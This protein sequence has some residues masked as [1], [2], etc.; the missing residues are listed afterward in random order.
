M[1]YYSTRLI[2]VQIFLSYLL[3]AIL[4]IGVW[5][6]G[7][8]TF[9][10]IG[11]VFFLALGPMLVYFHQHPPA[12]LGRANAVTVFSPETQRHMAATFKDWSIWDI[13]WMKI[14]RILRLFHTQ[15]DTSGQYGYQGAG[16]L[17]EISG[18]LL[19]LGLGVCLSN[20]KWPRFLL[21][22]LWGTMII[23]TGGLLT[24]N[25]PF[26]PRMASLPLFVAM[27][28]ALGLDFTLRPFDR[29]W[30]RFAPLIWMPIVL[31]VIVFAGWRNYEH[32][33]IRYIGVQ[34]PMTPL[35]QLAHRF[36][37]LPSDV[38]VRL[39]GYPNLGVGH[40]TFRFLAPQL[41]GKDIRNG[42]EYIENY[43]PGEQQELWVFVFGPNMK[44]YPGAVREH[45]GGKTETINARG[46]QVYY[47]LYWP[48]TAQ[49]G[50]GEKN[51]N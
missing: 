33:F 12:F 6:K 39:F 29:L 10:I 24:V 50:T 49:D 14:A 4:V 26:Y 28:V 30:G 43:E 46:S 11:I 22:L 27:V 7:F 47:K 38:Q 19:I 3:I 8:L 31:A 15:G 21:P 42:E 5:K 41:Q 48:P 16:M 2:S 23:T 51:G 40:G 1:T 45:P 37:E 25:T 32:Y 44:L 9:A 34:Q 35:T 36:E 13:A 17:D 20:W 18:V